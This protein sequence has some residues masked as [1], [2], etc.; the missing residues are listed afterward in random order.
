MRSSSFLLGLLFS[1]F[2]SFGQ[3]TVVD[4]EAAVSSYFKLPRET[5]YLHL[6]KSTYV[7]QDEIWFKGYVH[8]RKNGLPSLASTNFNIE[9]F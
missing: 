2:L 3:V 7:V 6:N 1:S 8:D 4:S 5:V 9:V